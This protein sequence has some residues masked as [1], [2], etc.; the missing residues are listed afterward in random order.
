MTDRSLN[1]SVVRG[2]YSIP[3]SDQGKM[4][5]LLKKFS[6]I[7]PALKKSEVIRIGILIVGEMNENELKRNLSRIERL[8]VGRRS[9]EKGEAISFD[10]GE[11]ASELKL[12]N[13]QSRKIEK[14]FDSPDKVLGKPRAEYETVLNGLLYIFS[15]NNQKRHLPE[16]LPSYTTCWRRLKEWKKAGSWKRI[17]QILLDNVD[18]AEKN[19][20]VEVLLR[21]FLIETKL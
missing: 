2:S 5:A 6:T 8:N 18:E 3:Q 7:A 11:K 21:I 17:S 19:Q 20:L 14:L 12:N 13:R 9:K 15:G 10:V 1:S 4:E 16:G